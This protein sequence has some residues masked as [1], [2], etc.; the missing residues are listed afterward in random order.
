M[1]VDQKVSQVKQ[2]VTFAQQRNAEGNEQWRAWDQNVRA[3]DAR[4]RSTRD[5]LATE[6]VCQ[7]EIDHMTLLVMESREKFPHGIPQPGSITPQTKLSFPEVPSPDG[8][9]S[10]K[11]GLYPRIECI[12]LISS[13]TVQDFLEETTATFSR[14][15]YSMFFDGERS[16]CLAEPPSTT[17]DCTMPPD[18][19]RVSTSVVHFQQQILREIAESKDASLCPRN[20]QYYS[21]DSRDLTALATDICM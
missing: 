10:L 16:S 6:E 8:L 13:K 4:A 21:S 15:P 11:E 7:D 5:L 12:P 14:G 9:K 3:Q 1:Q 2:G 20:Q 17:N 18:L 19:F